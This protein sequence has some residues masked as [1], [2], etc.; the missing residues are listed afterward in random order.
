MKTVYK[1]LNINDIHLDEETRQRSDY[2]DIEELSASILQHG[3]IQPIGVEDNTRRLVWG[4]RRYKACIEAGITSISCRIVPQGLSKIELE[5][6]ELEENIQRKNL[7]W[8]EECDA[9]DRIDKLKKEIHGDSE[10]TGDKSA[11]ST[12]KTAELL[13]KSS[14]GVAEKIA[15][16][17][18]MRAIPELRGCKTA[19][20]AKKTYK[21]IVESLAIKNLLDN[22]RESKSSSFK[23]AEH[24]YMLGDAIEGLKN[25]DRTQA[26]FAIVDPPYAISLKNIKKMNAQT[27]TNKDNL[28]QYNEWSKEEY[29]KKIKEV[30][31]QLYRVLADNA[32]GIWWFGQ[33]HYY[34]TLQTIQAAGFI[35]DPIPATWGKIGSPGQSQQPE[36][37]L[38]RA[39][40][41]FF[42]FRKGNPALHKRGVPNL[43]LYKVVASQKKIHPT[44]KPLGLMQ[45][46][47]DTFAFPGSIV[48]IPFLGSGVDLRACYSLNLKGFGWDLNNE[49]REKF[50]YR[51]SQDIEGGLYGTG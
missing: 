28:E 27:K 14:G 4:A 35:V 50:L 31:E 39:T 37:Y 24:H 8:Q 13:D 17:H 20:E 33:E 19:D 32:F 5:S 12:R 15:L 34:K 16:S 46:I 30:A 40:E 51:V 25:L 2:G 41:T 10:T 36:L 6:L 29:Y 7:S 43:F 18:A 26:T 23:F 38:G 3:L 47:L 11:W 44:E 42:C 1:E 45:E 9:L 49:Y 21:Q 22:E 48:I